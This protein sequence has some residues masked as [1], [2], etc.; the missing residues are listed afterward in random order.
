MQQPVYDI[1]IVG[2][3]PAGSLLSYLLGKAGFGKIALIDRATF[4]RDK[5][6]G[7]GLGPGSV[8]LLRRVGLEDVFKGYEAVRRLAVTA[9]KGHG[10]EG[11]I[12]HLHG[13]VP[14]GYIIRRAELD[15]ALHDAA[16]S[17]GVDDFQG[18]ELREATF[19]DGTW[20]LG[21]RLAKQSVTVTAK[22]LVGADGVSSKVRR[23][24]GHETNSPSHMAAAIRGYARLKPGAKNREAM[25]L[26]FLPHLLPFYGWV[27]PEGEIANIGLWVSGDH[28][29]SSGANLRRELAAYATQQGYDLDEDTVKSWPIPLASKQPPLVDAGRAV[30][31]VGDAA[32][33]VNPSTGEGIYYALAAAEMLAFQLMRWK[34]CS[35]SLPQ[36]LRAY[37]RGF[38]AQHRWHYLNNRLLQQ[39]ITK[40]W[41]AD[42]AIFACR[43]RPQTFNEITELM[44]SSRKRLSVGTAIHLCWRLLC[45]W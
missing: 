2:A 30:A 24:L 21:L 43:E 14:E 23:L 31:L 29:L 10:V 34:G 4:P 16:L 27:F 13:E 5:V 35:R 36:V 40:A 17:L 42:R 45:P 19:M 33:M 1:A 28:Q 7:D 8:A 6:C 11:P 41:V 44:L 25:A 37:R 39:A 38:M 20:S 3:G 18:H 9:P 12:P 22:V 32:S 15:N 26:D